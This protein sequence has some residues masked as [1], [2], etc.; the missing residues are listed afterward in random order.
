MPKIK[1]CTKQTDSC[2][3]S[4]S[5]QCRHWTG[6]PLFWI[7]GKWNQT[8]PIFVWSLGNILIFLWKLCIYVC[9]SGNFVFMCVWVEI[10]YGDCL[11]SLQAGSKNLPARPNGPWSLCD[12]CFHL[13]HV[14]TNENTCYIYQTH[15]RRH[16]LLDQECLFRP[17]HL[18]RA[19]EKS[20]LKGI[21]AEFA[22]SLNCFL[23]L[24]GLLMMCSFVWRMRKDDNEVL[25]TTRK[26]RIRFR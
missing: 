1:F 12:H 26:A 22:E 3:L 10:S 6:I 13:C 24:S 25:T 18:G 11:H 23:K 7:S 17:I 19:A 14:I 20:L 15:F 4:Y 8:L 21:Q 9:L 5:W 16:T 2:L